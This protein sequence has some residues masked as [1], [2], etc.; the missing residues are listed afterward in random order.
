MDHEGIERI[1]GHAVGVAQCG[2]VSDAR[3]LRR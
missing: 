1:Y 3:W 2:G